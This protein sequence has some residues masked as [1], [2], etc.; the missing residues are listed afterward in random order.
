MNLPKDLAP[1]RQSD[2]SGF[3][4][5]S[6]HFFESVVTSPALFCSDAAGSAAAFTDIWQH[7]VDGLTEEIALLDEDWTILLVNRSWARTAELYGHFSIVPGTNYLEFCRKL[8]GEGLQVAQEVVAGVEEII[9]GKRSGFE[10]IY[11]ASDPEQGH[12]HRLGVN[13]FEVAGRKFT[14]ITRYDVTRVIEL[15][16]LREDF[17]GSVMREQAED[18]RRIG[19]EIHDSTMQLLAS[20]GLMIGHLKR[21]SELATEQPILEEMQQLLT[22]AQREIRSISYLIHPPVLGKLKL[23]EALRALVEG[24]GRRTGLD[25]QFE[26]VDEPRLCC[27]AA[28]GAIYRIVQE[29]L[30]N[31][32]RHSKARHASVRLS[33]GSAVT[34]VVISDDGVGIPASVTAGVGLAG[35]R[36]RLA[37]LGGRLFIRRRSPGTAVIASLPSDLTAANQRRKR[38]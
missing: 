5:A 31:V 1:I 34:H 15:R 16:K 7:L 37:E 13:Q 21:T 28:E 32:H 2:T 24:F 30:S 3:K 36:S 25:V 35:M 29:A 11:R 4:A 23:A 8:A 26:G 17:S 19:R 22:E 20:I 33:Q 9:A 14:S 12:D 6:N 38:A 18:R 10:L 27:P